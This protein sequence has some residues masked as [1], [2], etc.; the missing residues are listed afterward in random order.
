[1]QTAR[2]TGF[3]RCSNDGQ[4]VFKAK[5]ETFPPCSCKQGVWEFLAT[6]NNISPI[7]VLIGK[8]L[9]HGTEIDLLPEVGTIFNFRGG[10]MDP[11]TYQVTALDILRWRGN[12]EIHVV[13]ERVGDIDPML[14]IHP[15]CLL[16]C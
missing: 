3:H 12:D 11:G 4:T 6:D 10:K 15:V 16:N 2:H 5:G 7:L 8:G 13:A 1:M 9:I 14:P